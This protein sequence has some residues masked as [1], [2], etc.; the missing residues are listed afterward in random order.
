VT[1]FDFWATWC[2]PCKELEPVLIELARAHPDT[3][4]IRR[5]DA[6]DWDSAA[7]AKHL[8]PGGFSLPHV[9]IFDATGTMV[10]EQ[11][12][13]PGKLQALVDAVRAAVAAGVAAATAATPTPSPTP[14]PTPTPTPTPTTT[15]T[16]TPTTTPTPTPTP[17]PTPRKARF[18]IQVT[19]AGFT[20]GNVTVP[21]GR[22]VTL[23]FTRK[24][25]ATCATE[26]VLELGGKKIE[27]KLPLDQPVELTL[28][29]PNAGTIKYACAMDM[30][31]GTITVR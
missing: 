1:I 4:A 12:S 16:P 27:K 2:E 15:P 6:V 11:S 22:P 21:R 8:T 10:L 14:A 20:P 5:I 29:F 26:V 28:T 13:A 7:V 17:A 9:K 24:T 31:R 19:D 23:V 25:A 18:S 3:V 30:V